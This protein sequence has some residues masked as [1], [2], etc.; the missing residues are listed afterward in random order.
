MQLALGASLLVH[1]ALLTLRIV[2]PQAFDRVF[3]DSPLEV[4]LVNSRSQERPDQAQAIAQAALA[5]GGQ[6]AQGR[7]TSPLPASAL[8]E[9]GQAL[10]AAQ[11]Q[12]EAMHMQQMALLA[13]RK[14]DLATQALPDPQQAA[15]DPQARERLERHR[16]QVKLLAEIERRIQEENARP[17]KRYISPA[18]RE[19]VYAVYYDQLR[20]KVEDF[21]TQHFPESSGRRL[22]GEL[23][24]QLA[25]NFDGQVVET[26]VE[27]SSGNPTLDRRAQSIARSAGPFGP[28]PE[29]VRA[30]LLR[31]G[32]NR[33]AFVQTF[34]FAP[35]QTL[36]TQ[37]G[38][39]QTAP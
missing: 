9:V 15:R 2:D 1:G 3:S 12:L 36:Q 4:I 7:A 18:T 11:Q 6:A 24:L 10:E 30:H 5:G 26:V 19:E 28:V 37:L 23:I 33:L 22:Y 8:S 25:V 29:H 34:R 35:D 16:Q 13:Q 17:K 20:R 39:R 38:V 27:K 21:G 31:S 32:F 14:Q